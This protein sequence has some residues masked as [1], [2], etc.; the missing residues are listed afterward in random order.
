MER[1]TALTVVQ[2]TWL[3]RSVL[4]HAVAGIADT[5]SDNDGTPNCLDSCPNNAPK[6]APG[7]Y[8]LCHC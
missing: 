7:A 5:D 3:I 6:I 2:M 1:Q 4:D 8:G